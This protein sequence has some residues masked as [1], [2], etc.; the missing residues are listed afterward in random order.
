M[1]QAH[2]LIVEDDPNISSTLALSLGVQGYR[3]S[4]AASVAQAQQQLSAHRFDC[5]LLDVSLPDGD[6][7]TLCADVRKRDTQLPILMLTANVTED[8]AVRGIESGADDYI[9]KPYGIAEL[10]AR[11]RRVLD[12]NKPKQIVFGAIRLEPDRRS[13]WVG[14]QE[15]DLGKREYDILLAL[16]QRN[17]DVLTREAILA[18]VSDGVEVYDRTIDSHLSHLRK[19]LKNAGATEQI[20]PVYGVGYR[21]VNT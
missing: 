9:R 10:S 12:K 21:L 14:E 6:G 7:Y 2:I 16:A 5:V 4:T 13:A 15:V 17:G 8:A 1:M 20:V 11:I 3:I 19:K 18:Q